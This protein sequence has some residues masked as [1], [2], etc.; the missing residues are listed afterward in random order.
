W[1]GVCHV[2]VDAAADLDMARR[3][4]VNGKAQSCATCNATE[5]LLVH[6]DVAG[7]FLPL[8]AKDLAA[9]GVV[10]RADEAAWGQEF[11]DLVL[12]L[13]TVASIDEALDHIARFGTNHTEAIVTRD[14]AAA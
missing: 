2:Y 5:C 11:L 14:E 8:V 10:V 6:R 7:R 4:V 9:A 3:I 1:K 13:R 12:A